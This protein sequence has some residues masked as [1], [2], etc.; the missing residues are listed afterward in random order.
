MAFFPRGQQLSV[1]LGRLETE[2]D[3][4]RLSCVKLRAGNVESCVDKGM[5]V[6]C[7]WVWG[8]AV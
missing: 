5:G 3:E 7:P 2:S 8:Y 1:P 6:Y 4:L